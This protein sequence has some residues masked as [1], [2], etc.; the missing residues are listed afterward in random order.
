MSFV[1]FEESRR[2]PA[3]RPTVNF[4]NNQVP[5]APH[6]AAG[7]ILRSAPSNFLHPNVPISQ[8]FWTLNMPPGYLHGTCLKFF[9]ENFTFVTFLLKA[10]LC[11]VIIVAITTGACFLPC[12][13]LV[14]TVP[15]RMNAA[16]LA[17]P[18]N[19]RLGWKTPISWVCSF[20][21]RFYFKL[22]I[23]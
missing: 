6:W 18:P 19:P 12:F 23:L 15:T 21:T 10:T 7:T 16:G 1:R 20:I 14:S 8:M 13:Q 4:L 17:Q 11:F 22:L 3:D 5:Q 2:C 9:R